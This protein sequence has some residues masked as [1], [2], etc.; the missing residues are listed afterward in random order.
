MR[1]KDFRRTEFFPDGRLEFGQT[2]F[3]RDFD[4]FVSFNLK[5]R[6]GAL[7]L[8]EIYVRMDSE[9]KSHI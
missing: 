5:T 6:D 8:V 7:S 3:L 2:F 4:S 9:R 1:S